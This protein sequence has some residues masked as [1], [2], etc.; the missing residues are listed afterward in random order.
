MPLIV[1]DRV[2]E[3]SVTSGTGMLTLTGSPQAFQTFSSAIGNGNTTYYSITETGTGNFEVGLGTVGAGTLTRDTVL[4]SSNAG[5]LVNFGSAAKDVFCTYPAE[6]AILGNTSAISS[7]GT[8]NVVLSDS[9]VIN[10]P[11]LNGNVSANVN[12]RSGTLNTLLPLAGGTSEVG[13]ATDVN[14]LVRFNG[15][16]GG[17]EII[18]GGSILNFVLTTSNYIQLSNPASGVYIDCNNISQLNLSATEELNALTPFIQ[19]INIRFPN[20]TKIKEFKV[21]ISKQSG[22]FN[23]DTFYITP[24][25]QPTDPA[26]FYNVIEADQPTDTENTRPRFSLFMF[27]HINITFVGDSYG[28]EGASWSRLPLQ[29][30][31]AWAFA[32][33]NTNSLPLVGVILENAGSIRTL[34]TGVLQ[35]SST[36]QLPSGLWMVTG[37]VTFNLSATTVATEILAGVGLST[38]T[39]APS[40]GSPFSSAVRTTA[41]LPSAGD[42]VM[43]FSPVMIN[44]NTGRT[45]YGNARATFS[46]GTITARIYQRAIRI[47]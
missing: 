19:N 16:A 42:I 6:K 5:S 17:A 31:G 47:A 36:L 8:G 39:S 43:A 45:I 37:Y 11:I 7:T 1:K 20:S 22:A 46:A 28:G 26:Q 18:K 9:P 15:T 25:F 14:A 30:E 32:S 33:P 34:T 12:L 3:N 10:T 24:S 21:F 44:S 13:Y 35:S 4:E 38:T 2:R 40:V 27:S 23:F 29:G 41:N